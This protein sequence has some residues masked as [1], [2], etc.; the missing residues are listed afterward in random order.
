MGKKI[1]YNVGD[2]IG[3]CS[4]IKELSSIKIGKSNTIRRVILFKC[5]CGKEF[6]A[7][8]VNV[9]R[10]TTTSC[11]CIRDSKIKSQGLKN[12]VHG[13]RKHPLY[14]MW[15]GML[16]RCNNV[17]NF[18]YYNYGGRGIK[19]CERWLDVNLFIKDMF[20]LYK[21][22]LELDRINVNGNYEKSNCRWVTRK[23]N[24]NNTRRNRYVEYKGEIK[25]VSQ[26]SDHLDIP[27]KTLL[28]RL[29]HWD[30]EKAFN[31]K[32]SYK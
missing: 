29:N 10:G 22:G 31:Y 17:N 5:I 26:W 9:K 13:K 7:F 20:P 8:L 14:R 30:V 28:Q 24:M 6:S 21:K 3:N 4:F 27:Y 2:K 25:T 19:V 1:H 18:N 32:I 15:Q 23:E 11:G 16:D 12:K